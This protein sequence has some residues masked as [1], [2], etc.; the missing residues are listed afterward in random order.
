[1]GVN[2]QFYGDFMRDFSTKLVPLL[3]DDIRVLIY[4]GVGPMVQ[5][6]TFRVSGQV[7]EG[8]AEHFDCGAG[9]MH[10][11]YIICKFLGN[12][13]WVDGLEPWCCFSSLRR[14]PCANFPVKAHPV[15]V[16]MTQ[17]PSEATGYVAD[18]DE[19]IGCSLFVAS[20][21]LITYCCAL[22]CASTLQVTRT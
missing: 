7:I 2:A 15:R 1:M 19:D 16:T 3:E 11:Y 20:A 10:V 9:G 5:G 8:I 22:P 13:G 12:R 21:L 17:S 14:S 4:A 6:C 18:A